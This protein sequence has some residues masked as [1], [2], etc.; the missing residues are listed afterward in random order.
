MSWFSYPLAGA[1]VAGTVSLLGLIISKESK[2]SEFRQQ[3]ID[4]LR[5]DIASLIGHALNIHSSDAGE[6]IAESIQNANKLT[7]RI[8]LRLKIGEEAG[9]AVI[10]KLQALRKLIHSEAKFEVISSATDDLTSVSRILLKGEWE[11]VKQ[12]EPVYRW[13]LRLTIVALIL[14]GAVWLIHALR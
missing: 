7:A 1:I 12:G 4:E 11:R 14:L 13:T 6:P 5:R 3:W 10:S 2:I 9:E 8:E